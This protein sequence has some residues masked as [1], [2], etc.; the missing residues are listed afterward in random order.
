MAKKSQGDS[1][2]RDA[3]DTIVQR[4]KML[5]MLGIGGLTALAGCNFGGGSSTSTPAEDDTPTPGSSPTASAT[6]GGTPT[7]GDTPTDGEGTAT[8]EPMERYN[9]TLQIHRAPPIPADAQYQPYAPTLASWSTMMDNYFWKRSPADSNFYGQLVEEWDYSPGVLDFKVA[10]NAYFWNGE[11]ITAQNALEH[12]ELVDYM[13]GGATADAY[14]FIVQTE[15]LSE[16]EARLYLS[17]TYTEDFALQNTLG[18]DVLTG[19]SEWYGEYLEQ[20]RDATTTDEIRSIRSTVRN[21]TEK[22][23]KYFHDGPFKVTDAEE[24]RWILSLRTSD[25]TEGDYTPLFVDEI[26]YTTVEVVAS[27]QGQRSIEAFENGDGLFRYVG[28]DYDPGFET[29]IIEQTRPIDAFGYAFNCSKPPFDNHH[30]RRAWAYMCDR[31]KHTPGGPNNMAVNKIITGLGT[32]VLESRFDDGGLLDSL[33]EYGYDEIKRDKAKEEMESGGFERDS[34]GN[35]LYQKGDNEGQP[36]EITVP[37]HSWQGG[38]ANAATAFENAMADFGI[39][40]SVQTEDSVSSLNIPLWTAYNRLEYTVGQ[41]YWG[42][43]GPVS[44]YSNIYGNEFMFGAP[45]S[46]FPETIDLPPLGEPDSTVVETFEPVR[47]ANQLAVTN[48]EE[49]FNELTKKLIW[50]TNQAVPKFGVGK[51]LIRIMLNTEKWDMSL[52]TADHPDKWI[53]TP[54]RA[55]WNNGGMTFIPEEDR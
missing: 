27:D 39:N 54:L 47:M 41:A 44:T 4:R 35:W 15:Q 33:T 36:I 40:I 37:V 7:A 17:D 6:P 38:S 19:S 16:Y 48:N 31:K 1:S 18:G 30:F 5:E 3:S 46:Q 42:G 28:D 20:F 10:E 29:S 45:G 49:Q 43:A 8:A 9:P 13:E 12:I 25:V 14:E 24:D 11:H 50:V 55:A 51:N 23:P 32:D 53:G 52:P 22:D 34:G 2:G 21:T 26:N